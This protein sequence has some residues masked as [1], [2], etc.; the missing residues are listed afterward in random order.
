MPTRIVNAEHMAAAHP[1]TFEILT[2]KEREN[3]L[4]GASV[5]IAI[6][7][8]DDTPGERFLTVVKDRVNGRYIVAVDNDLVTI[9][10]PVG[11]RLEIGP[12]HIYGVLES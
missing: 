1:E 8:K 4:I 10:W 5:K 12:E 6:E 9:D 3:V 7:H 2:R 11:H